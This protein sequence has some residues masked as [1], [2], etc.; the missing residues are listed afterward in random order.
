MTRCWLMQTKR[1]QEAMP[2]LV[3]VLDFEG[4]Q[5]ATFD[6]VAQAMRSNIRVNDTIGMMS[7]K[8]NVAAAAIE[9]IEPFFEV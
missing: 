2:T 8:D 4:S 3:L 9:G 1:P 7:V 6:K 5:Q